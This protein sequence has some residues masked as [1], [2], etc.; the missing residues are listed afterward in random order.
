MSELQWMKK[1]FE[2]RLPAFRSFA[3]RTGPYFENERRFKEE[4]RELFAEEFPK[5]VLQSRVAPAQAEDFVER[6]LRLLSRRVPSLPGPQN[7]ISWR[8]ARLV[9]SFDTARRR[10]VGAALADLL[11]GEGEAPE[12]LER[13]NKAYWQVLESAEEPPQFWFTR[14]LPTLLLMLQDPQHNMYVGS[15]IIRHA[16]KRLGYDLLGN[17]MLDAAQYRGVLAMAAHVRGALEAWGWEPQ[18][19]I[20]VQGFLW[21]ALVPTYRDVSGEVVGPEARSWIFRADPRQH[22]VLTALQY[23]DELHWPVQRHESDIRAGNT[24]FLWI[25]GEETGIVA[26]AAVLSEPAEVE[27]T[28]EE[29]Q[30]LR[31]REETGAA[32]L[33]VKLR[34]VEVLE[35]PIPRDVFAEHPQLSGHAILTSPESTELVL[36]P[37]EA[38]AVRGL[39]LAA[40]R[41]SPAVSE[42]TDEP[43]DELFLSREELATMLAA[44][45]RRKNLI[46][47]GP[48]GTGKTFVARR[49]AYV[50]IGTADE[51]AV[52]MVQ[53]H[54]SYTYEDFVQGVRSTPSGSLERRNGPFY[55]FCEKA[56]D[57]E[58]TCHVFIIDDVNRC[59]V[60]KVFGDLL[61]LIE[62]DKRGEE[63]AVP[64]THGQGERFFV[65]P[66]VH[67]IGTMNS[68]D[69]TS[70]MDHALRRRFAFARLAPAFHR[71]EF[72]ALLTARGASAELA[73]LVA[74]RLGELNEVIVNSK[75]LGPGFAVGHS[76][77]CPTA[78]DT[79]D[80]EWYRQVVDS[81]IR[82]LIE[83]YWFDD[84]AR[85]DSLIQRLLA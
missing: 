39:I 9:A 13:F 51:S 52:E 34:V 12:R 23:L 80:D 5:D 11:A 74:E 72:R 55:R 40:T 57:R 7:F 32:Q 83:E 53:F 56:R 33:W 76:Y 22:D 29:A 61:V 59:D 36:T 14:G 6:L 3:D 71:S 31:D 46:L 69:R 85:A 75:N 67:I 45:R 41:P 58:D 16:G 79:P 18:D 73:A 78:S 30:Y 44:L 10:T 17:S 84:P 50:A 1:R 49:L 64:L 26:R 68:A 66:N 8:H 82:P 47:E 77:F 2:E 42:V 4:I 27:V 38:A 19:L 81:E 21:V 43:L 70:A 63:Y 35:F 60:S 15:S 48:P 28:P 65:P 54:P 37:T 25:A 20:D 62:A 24:A